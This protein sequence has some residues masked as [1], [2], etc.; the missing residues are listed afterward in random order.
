MSA[1]LPLLPIEALQKVTGHPGGRFDIRRAHENLGCMLPTLPALSSGW[2]MLGLKA[3]GA[4][5]FMTAAN[6]VI[7]YA[8]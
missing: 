6:V 8:S 3:L 5:G 1:G 4:L 7:L 2:L